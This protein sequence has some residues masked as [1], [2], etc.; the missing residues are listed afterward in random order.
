MR[1][2][3]ST[4]RVALL[5]LAALSVFGFQLT[6]RQPN[7]PPP[8]PFDRS[9]MLAH[10]AYHVMLPTYLEFEGEAK[11]LQHATS[12]LCDAPT[13]SRLEAAQAH[14][15]QAASGWKRSEAFQL[16]LTQTYAKSI[17]FWPTR[18]P[19]LRLALTSTQ[20]IT[21]S[22]VEA[23][24]AAAHGLSAMEHLLFDAEAGQTAV[25]QAI[26][27]GPMA[28]RQCPYLVAMA[29]HLAD[30]AQAVAQF[31]RPEGADFS[32][33]VA[34]AG[35]GGT[36]YPTSHQAISDIVNQLVSA[37]ETVQNNKIGKPLRGNGQ[38]PWP[39]TV[40]AGRSG[41]ST[42][43]ILATLEGAFAVYSGKAGAAVGPG[44]D[45]FLAAL[46]SDLGPRITRQFD[47]ALTAV[48]AIPAPLRVAII[49]QPQTVQAAYQAVHQLLILL[50]VD[51]TNVLSVTVDF[52]DN[53]G[54]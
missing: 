33:T 8:T 29:T 39:H 20:P 34:H 50:K 36:T 47:A 15:R 12:Q 43:L 4:T 16:D 5:A 24:G 9:Q 23:M 18:P 52:S 7:T 17:G 32:G 6:S 46:G 10:L 37:V 54:D 44:F 26:Q 1:H 31:W 45:A 40:E 25:L 21:P 13:I 53:D 42:E 38:K 14:W 30:K 2:L 19:R 11:A 35:Q 51:M 41:A 48:R 22:F 3:S 27:N 28:K 49:E